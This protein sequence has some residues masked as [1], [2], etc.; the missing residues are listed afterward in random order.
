MIDDEPRQLFGGGY[1]G[2]IQQYD[3]R[4][5][6]EQRPFLDDLIG[7]PV[8]AKISNIFN[9]LKGKVSKG[10]KTYFKGVSAGGEEFTS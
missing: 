5:A 3:Y 8:T 7:A 6:F 10:W 4:P 2:Y 1:N 9:G